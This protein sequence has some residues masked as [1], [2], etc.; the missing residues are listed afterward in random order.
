MNFKRGS[1]TILGG[2]F[3]ECLK[4][5]IQDIIKNGIPGRRRTMVIKLPT[6]GIYM[7]YIRS[8]FCGMKVKATLNDICLLLAPRGFL[9]NLIK[10]Y[11]QDM[12]LNNKKY[13]Y[14]FRVYYKNKVI[15][16]FGK[17]KTPGNPKKLVHVK[18]Y[19]I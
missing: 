16:Y 7:P 2:I 8:Y 18:L 9:G 14:W 15:C 19:L 1:T 17:L 5:A 10:N 12:N 4:N 11:L 13:I 3:N 6:R